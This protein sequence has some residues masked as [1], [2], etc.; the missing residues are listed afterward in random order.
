MIAGHYDLTAAFYQLIL[1]PSM[2]Y[3]C[4]CWAPGTTT[5]AD[6]QRAKLELICRKLGLEPGQRLLDM[7]CG[8][9]S[10]TIHAARAQVQ[11][12][13]VTLSREQGG[14]VRQR[15]RGLGLATA[16]R[17]GSRTTGIRWTTATTRS[18]RWRWA[19]TSVPRS[20]RGSARRCT[21]GCG[22]ADG[23]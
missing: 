16:P 5:L 4:A 14:Y 13:G 7:G 15:A 21:P 1:D 22:R 19:S 3:S 8:W 6:A 10:L 23:C 11:V 18:R 12:T 2:A 9:G 17:S 20:T